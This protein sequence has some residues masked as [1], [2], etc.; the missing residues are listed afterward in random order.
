VKGIG[1]S[2]AILTLFLIG[3]NSA[4]LVC[5]LLSVR[6]EYIRIGSSNQQNDKRLAALNSISRE[7]PEQWGLYCEDGHLK[8]DFKGNKNYFNG[9]FLLYMYTRELC[10][11]KPWLALMKTATKT[12]RFKWCGVE[13]NS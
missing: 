9:D 6:A 5:L 11:V 4:C 2:F 7:P 13:N 3:R 12:A 1:G 10:V 8:V